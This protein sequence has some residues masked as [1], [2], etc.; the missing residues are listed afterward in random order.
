MH[1]SISR[2]HNYNTDYSAKYRT[3]EKSYSLPFNRTIVSGREDW[4]VHKSQKH[5]FTV[6]DCFV[7]DKT[8]HIL[9]T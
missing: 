4:V 8:L 5:I 1:R 9:G 6:T 3:T 2:S 7:C